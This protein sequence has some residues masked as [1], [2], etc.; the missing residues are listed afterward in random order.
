MS[1]VECSRKGCTN[2]QTNKALGVCH[3]HYMRW[4][5]NGDFGQGEIRFRAGGTTPRQVRNAIESLLAM[6][7]AQ[8]CA[9]GGWRITPI[10]PGRGGVLL[11]GGGRKT[12]TKI[13]HATL[14][15]WTRRGWVEVEST[16]TDSGCLRVAKITA[17]GRDALKGEGA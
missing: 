5:R 15:N 14:N 4:R 9:K 17:D 11:K 1:A 6:I 13:S 7:G 3:C 12:P 16:H 2:P 10:T 8:G